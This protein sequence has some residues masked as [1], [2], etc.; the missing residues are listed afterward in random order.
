MEASIV[1]GGTILLI[2]SAA[3]YLSKTGILAKLP[4][5]KPKKVLS[6]QEKTAQDMMNVRDIKDRFL[7]TKDNLV[8]MYIRITPISVDLLSDRE[9]RNVM[10]TLT[11]ELSSERNPMKFLA[12]SR[13]VD[14]SPLITEYSQLMFT[15]TSKQKELLRSE[16]MVM[17]NY[18]LSGEVV[19]RQ[20]YLMVWSKMEENC[21]RELSKRTADLVTKF[22]SC[23]I[24]C[25]ILKS[26]DIVRLCNL[27][28]NPAYSHLEDGDFHATIPILGGIQDKP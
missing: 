23:A 26:Q 14:I 17:S 12:V 18:A 9:K 6:P 28:N 25:D 10:R 13:P 20:F 27:I 5:R 21:E 3:L 11:A 15:A 19:E 2:S 4:V 8:M 7:Y 1:I 16:M 24:R 22:E